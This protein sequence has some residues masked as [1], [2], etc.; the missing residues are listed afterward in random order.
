MGKLTARATAYQ[1]PTVNLD[2]LVAD[3]L[4]PS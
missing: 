4:I 2:K 1:V 3:G